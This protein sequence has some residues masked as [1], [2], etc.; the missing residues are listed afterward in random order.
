M[1]FWDNLPQPFFVLAPMEDVTNVVFRHVVARAARPDVFVS[2]FTNAASFCSEKGEHSTRGRMTF[3][4]DEQPIVAQIWGKNPDNF[5]EM[6][7]VLAE[8]GFAGIDI[9]MGC[10]DKK[11]V[12]S[13]GGSVLI[14][15]PELAVELIKAARC[16]W[17][18]YQ[19]SFEE[20]LQPVTT[21]EARQRC[22]ICDDRSNSCRVP[23]ME[24]GN[25]VIQPPPI[26][27]KTRLGYLKV[28]EWKPWLTTLLEQ[29]LANLTVHLRTKKEMSKVPAHYELIPEIVAL[30]DAVAPATKLT[31]NGDIRNRA[32]GL[33]LARQNP[34]INGLMIGRGV[35][36]NPFCFT[37]KENLTQTE[38]FNLLN[39]HLDLF[40]QYQPRKF[41][42]LKRFFKVYI[43]DFPGASELR[44]RLME[45]KSTAEAREVLS[46]LT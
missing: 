29:N 32:H 12:K 21:D 6:A 15:N 46:S 19:I 8:R 30:R 44:A 37:D 16:G 24:S 23:R 7:R 18:N 42:P 36:A 39:Y 31:I 3:T 17:Q 13:G 26:S 5:R 43:R 28:E 11:V 20:A 45:T 38:L 1:N 10:P 33:D 41:D 40:D 4:P 35:F 22:L 14:E 27:V 9:N 25:S 34:G 2:E